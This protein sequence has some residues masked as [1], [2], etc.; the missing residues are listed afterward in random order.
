[1]TPDAEAVGERRVDLA[2]LERRAL[3]FLGGRRLK[4]SHAHQLQRQADQYEADVG[5]Q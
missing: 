5:R 4:V 3:L 2:G 1:L